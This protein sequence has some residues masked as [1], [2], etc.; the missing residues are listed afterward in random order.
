MGAL[1][2]VQQ[3]FLHWFII[4]SPG[5]IGQAGYPVRI[6]YLYQTSS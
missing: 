3:V 5:H 4:L 1:G 6:V 2:Y